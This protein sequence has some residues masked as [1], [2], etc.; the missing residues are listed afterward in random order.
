MLSYA[1]K[2]EPLKYYIPES[3]YPATSSTKEY[4]ISWQVDYGSGSVK[5]AR[6]FY[7]VTD[8]KGVGKFKRK[9]R[10]R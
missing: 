7:R 2:I 10:L 1:H 8:E 9:W 6:T 3:I 4:V 5:K